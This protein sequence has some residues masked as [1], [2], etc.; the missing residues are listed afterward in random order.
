MIEQAAKACIS[1]DPVLSQDQGLY[2]R[3]FLGLLDSVEIWSSK[4]HKTTASRLSLK[5]KTHL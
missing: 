2:S 1:Q 3:E 5:V 4:D